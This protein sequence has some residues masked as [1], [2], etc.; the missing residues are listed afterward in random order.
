MIENKNR[1][2]V[3]K[4]LEKDSPEEVFVEGFCDLIVYDDIVKLNLF[5]RPIHSKEHINSKK[6]LKTLT[7]TKSN[8]EKFVNTLN[9]EYTNI[10]EQIKSFD[11]KKDEIKNE[12]I[13][14]PKGPRVL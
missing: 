8:F 1:I 3:D 10:L 9:G 11:E 5:S 6:I 14:P 12:D 2:S 4:I 7:F 13:T